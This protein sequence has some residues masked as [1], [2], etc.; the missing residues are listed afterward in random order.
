MVGVVISD[1]ASGNFPAGQ[2]VIQNSR[3]RLTRGVILDFGSATAPFVIGDSV[4]VNTESAT[5]TSVNGA[6]HIKGLSLASVTKAKSGIEVTPRVVNLEALT[7]KPGEYEG[8]LVRIVAGNATPTPGRSAKYSGDKKLTDGNGNNIILHT[9]PT[10]SFA[11]E[12]LWASATY[13]GV[14]LMGIDPQTQEPTV[15]FSLRSIND[16][17]DP[18]GPLYPGFPEGFNDPSL[19]KDSYNMNPLRGV[20]DNTVNFSTGSWKL[21]YSIVGQTPGRDRFTGTWG[22][23]MQDNRP[24]SQSPYVQMNFDLPNGA[25]KVTYIYGAYY[26]DASS[27]WWIEYSQDQGKTWKQV[28]PTMTEAG[29]WTRTATVLMDITGPVRFRLFKKGLGATQAPNI[30]NGRFA[31]DDFAIYSNTE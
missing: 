26:T 1:P 17:E 18:S 10:A 15:F 3:R 16:V 30:F 9:E 24:E 7:A 22:I 14:P 5:L 31:F 25:S 27:T 19:L 8:T 12:R 20:V 13:T 29:N 28:G 2:V 6:L 21:F 11:N 4:V 23:R